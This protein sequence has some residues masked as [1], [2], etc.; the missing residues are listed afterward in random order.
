MGCQINKKKANTHYVTPHFKGLEKRR[1]DDMI[2]EAYQRAG[3]S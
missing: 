3:D 1:K 2:K